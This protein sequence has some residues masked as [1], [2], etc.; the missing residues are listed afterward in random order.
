[1]KCHENSGRRYLYLGSGRVA[2]LSSLVV[3]RANP[4]VLS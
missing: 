2:G 4:L 3:K 1:M